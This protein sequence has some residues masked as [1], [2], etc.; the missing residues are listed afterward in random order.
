MDKIQSKEVP[1][2]DGEI[3]RDSY[4][5]NKAI[6]KR[7]KNGWENSKTYRMNMIFSYDEKKERTS[8]NNIW[9]NTT[10]RQE[11]SDFYRSGI[12]NK[13]DKY[14]SI[15]IDVD[16]DGI[17]EYKDQLFKI[18]NYEP[19]KKITKNKKDRETDY[20]M[21]KILIFEQ[22]D[23][24]YFFDMDIYQIDNKYIKKC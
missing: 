8:T 23:N 5:S 21:D 6:T 20:E 24:L 13:Y 17:F 1:L 19:Y 11:E 4:R 9:N 2:M 16:I 22:Y 18:F 15:W 14:S 12:I 3:M 10:V 7:Q